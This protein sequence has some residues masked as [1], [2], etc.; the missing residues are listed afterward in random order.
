MLSLVDK[1]YIY[2]ICKVTIGPHLGMQA[3]PMPK[4]RVSSL[5]SIDSLI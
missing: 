5:I 4:T 2:D 3:K 1:C